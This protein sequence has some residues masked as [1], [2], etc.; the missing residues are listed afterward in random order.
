MPFQKDYNDQAK[1]VKYILAAEKELAK[2]RKD[3]QD[4]D[5]LQLKLIKEKQTE[6]NK[7]KKIQKDNAKIIKDSLSDF[8]D[9]DDSIVSFGN[10]L[11]K[12]TKFVEKQRDV[13][14]TIKVATSSIAMELAAG[15]TANKKTQAQVIAMNNSYK[16]MHV[17]IAD[18]NKEY[19]LG[20]ISN[21]ERIEQIKQQSESFQDVAA[22]IDMSTISSKDLTKQIQSM[23]NE[24]HS[25]TEAMEKSEMKTEKLD[26]IF[27]SFEGIPALGEVNTLLKTNIKDTVAFKAAVFALGAALGAAAMNYFGAPMKAAL[28]AQKEREQNEI[29]TIADVAKLRKDAEFIPAQIGQERLE[30]EIEA[31]N[32]INNLMHEAAYAGQKAAIQFSASMQSGAAQFERAA[33]T[34]LFGNKIGSVGY[35][36]AQLQL[37]GIGADKVAS[38]MEAASMATGKMPTAKAA[39]DMAVMAERTGQSVDD[40][41]TINEAFMRM[42]GMSADVAMNMQEGMRNMA[43]QAGIGLG[44]LMKEVAESSKEALGYQIKSG[45]ALAKAVAYTQSMGLSFGDVAKSGKNMV[46]NYKDSIKAEMQLSS[47]LGEQV[48]LSEVR[49]KF[50][51]GDQAGAL[52][53]LKA[54]GLDPADMDMFQQQALQDSLGGMDLSSLSKVANNTGKS[55]GNLAAGNAKGGNK[56]FL[57]RTQQAEASLSAKE[58]SISA[59]TAIVDAKLSKEIA[60]AYLASPEYEKYKKE[61][62]KAAVAARELESSMTDAWKAT[63]AYKKSLSDTTKLNFVDT[64]KEG[65]L[66]GLGAVG[67]GLLTTGISKMFG[68]KAGGIAGMI[69]GGGGGGEEDGAGSGATGGPIASVAAQITAAEPALK[70]AKTLGQNLKDFGNGVGSFIKSVGKGMGGA[71]EAILGGFGRGM[72]VI[73]QNAGYVMAGGVAIA[74]VIAS[75]GAGIAAASWIMGKA[76]PTL[77]E[78]LMS[79]NDVDGSNLKQVGLGV[80][81]L[82]A[83]L[84]GMGAGAVL[85]GIGN[86]VG[87]LFGGGI[88]DTIKKVE[89]F[90]EANINAAKV[91]NNA[92]AVVAY[93]KSMVAMGA[94]NALG[95]IGNLVGAIA[96]SISGFFEKEPPIEKM[97][98]F[99]NYNFNAKR[100]GENA[101]AVVSYAKA[102][103]AMGA[104]NALG[105]IGNMVGA[106]ADSIA[107]FFEKKPPIE[108]MKEF[109]NYNFDPKKVGQNAEAVTAYAKAMVE[110]G[111]GSAVSGL[112]AAAGAIGDSVAKF[113][114][115]KPPLAKMQ[116]FAAYQIGDV[117]NLEKNAKAFTIFGMAMQSYKGTGESM[118][119]QLGEGIAKFFGAKS[120]LDKMKEFAAADLGDISKLE[121]N[122][123]AFTL[124]GNAMASY[125]GTKDSMWHSLGESIAS[126]FGGETPLTKMKAFAAETF[127]P[128]QVGKN[129]EAFVLFGNAMGQ[130]KGTQE[131]FFSQL[132]EGLASFFSGGK[133]DLMQKFR[134][135]AQLDA[136]GINAAAGAIVNFNNSLFTFNTDRAKLVGPA[137]SSITE[138]ISLGAGNTEAENLNNMAQGMNAYASAVSFAATG[139]A[140]LITMST[141]IDTFSNALTNLSSALERLGS[142]NMKSINDLPWIRMTAF[143]AA[144]GKIVL[145]QSANNSFN[146]A[147]DTAK[148][149]DKLASDT[150]TNVQISKNLQALMAVL[151]GNANAAN[152]Q[153]NIDGK[154]VTNMI[155]K[156][157]ADRKAGAGNP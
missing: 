87:E 45:P 74:A 106:I 157:E 101:D 90:S 112:G 14:D 88:E 2:L 57:S 127:D 147:Q 46:M 47:L 89:K 22:K 12:N 73:G 6:L 16:A 5:A 21:A 95:G 1:V 41:S 81:A 42:D 143:A 71:I 121:G 133:T 141:G 92:D 75:I 120:S 55:G 20:R 70:K 114:D 43:D 134:E 61:Q 58:A 155:T 33:K 82:G 122:A 123:K 117:A 156:R 104:G 15:G 59:N 150:K 62:A 9:M 129:A 53:S 7:L 139:I 84:V 52:D 29:D 148:N 23:V 146:I 72:A 118:W 144:G 137:L 91:K 64:M 153:L 68:K 136:A 13:F 96:D 60:D 113:F 145:A 44:N 124:F 128:V 32:Q 50:A 86:L 24:G 116:E 54:Q 99:A 48:D 103:V 10:Q 115:A 25:F 102:M 66:D 154:A 3:A 38:A 49:A 111:K 77:A 39:A 67:G 11:K 108:K 36:A 51:A 4:D 100:V 151:A 132:A 138:S 30:N 94:G 97:K 140:G 98:K 37:A 131:G 28:Q 56:D 142:V 40:I 76:L 85:T 109:A 18:I 126:F 93:A 135:F 69:T 149:I 152:F 125:Q 35:G 65:L 26:K 80:A 78:G 63:D 79:F 107:G 19:A 8:E 31:T 105:G 119:H 110:L 27:E 130:Y 34:A 17:S 83:G